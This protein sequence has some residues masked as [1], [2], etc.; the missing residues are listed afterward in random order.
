MTFYRSMATI[1]SVIG[2]IGVLGHTITYYWIKR[3][4]L[5]DRTSSDIRHLDKLGLLIFAEYWKLYKLIK[6][7]QLPP[8][9]VT[10]ALKVLRLGIVSMVI[11]ILGLGIMITGM[12]GNAG[13]FG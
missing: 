2:L 10:P 13:K 5:F 1:G 6:T 12:F 3:F 9:Q 11:L 7:G 8:S 4:K